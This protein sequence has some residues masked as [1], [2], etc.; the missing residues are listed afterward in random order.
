MPLRLHNL[1]AAKK[2]RKKRVGRGNA[3]GHGTY[4]TR[5]IKGQRARS[6]GKKG[7]TFFLQR[8]KQIP[9]LKGFK[10]R[11]PKVS[12]VNLKELNQKF[13]SGDLISPQTLRKMGLV[14]RIEKGVK[15]LG[16]GKLK[17]ENLR[18]EG[19]R[20]SEVAQKQIEKM[21]G[22]IQIKGKDFSKED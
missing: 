6:G 10:S 19:C 4:S 15:I 11:K 16:E 21:G 2:K 7:R 5:G 14:D 18:I 3:S 12:I 13:K 20:V 22:K 8:L 9:K 1:K 17:L